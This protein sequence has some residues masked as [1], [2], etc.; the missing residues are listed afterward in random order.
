MNVRAPVCVSVTRSDGSIVF[1]VQDQGI[2][3]P[4]EGQ[5]Q[6]FDEFYR[7]NNVGTI[8]GTGLGLAIV[9]RA[10]DVMCGTIAVDSA[11]GLGTKFTITLPLK[12][13]TA[14]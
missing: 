6:L 7:A 9:K 12:K 1:H 13:P 3:I 2:G 4:L 14:G 8:S 10:V 11:V 5:P